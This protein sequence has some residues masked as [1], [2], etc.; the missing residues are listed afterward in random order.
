MIKLYRKPASL[1]LCLFQQIW[2]LIFVYFL[3][4]TKSK[5]KLIRIYQVR[6]KQRDEQTDKN[7]IFHQTTTLQAGPTNQVDSDSF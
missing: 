6:D 7:Q 5:K 2:A 1:F 3:P 4:T